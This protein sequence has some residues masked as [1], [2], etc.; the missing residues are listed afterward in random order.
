MLFDPEIKRCCAYCEESS[1]LDDRYVLCSRKGPV[2]FDFCCR[3]Y[4]YDPLRR[5]PHP[6]V[7]S[8]KK[9]TKKDFKL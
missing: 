7:K 6:P 8:S 1:D 3:H 9:F 4:R 2:D 5:Q